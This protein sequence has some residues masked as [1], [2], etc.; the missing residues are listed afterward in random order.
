MG[1]RHK[2]MIAEGLSQLGSQLPTGPDQ[3]RG[4]PFPQPSP[5]PRMGREGLR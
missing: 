3:E 1:E 4:H 5:V 2:V